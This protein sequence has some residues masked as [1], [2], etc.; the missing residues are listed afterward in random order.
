MAFIP[1]WLVL[2]FLFKPNLTYTPAS[3]LLTIPA[4]MLGF[5]IRFLLEST[6]TLLVFLDRRVWAIYNFYIAFAMLINGAFVSA[7]LMPPWVQKFCQVLP[8]QL[9]LSFPVLLALNQ[10]SAEMVVVNFGLQF[11][12]LF[13]L[14]GLFTYMW[15]RAIKQFSAVGA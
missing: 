4:V 12:W 15:G 2:V 10:L 11:V 8:F 9:T 3:L 7:S 6:V 5:L 1:I 14:F 13:V